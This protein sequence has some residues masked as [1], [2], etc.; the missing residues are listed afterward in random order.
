MAKLV[1]RALLAL[2]I[3]VGAFGFGSTPAQASTVDHDMCAVFMDHAAGIWL[4]RWEGHLYSPTLAAAKCREGTLYYGDLCFAVFWN[5]QNPD[6]NS[7][8]RTGN[9]IASSSEYDCPGTG[10]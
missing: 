7:I 5:P 10:W 4:E 9:K 8:V 1:R 3:V 2:A 6:P